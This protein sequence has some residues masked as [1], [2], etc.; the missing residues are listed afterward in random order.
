MSDDEWKE[1]EKLAE[2]QEAI[3]AAIAGI[4]ERLDAGEERRKCLWLLESTT[5]SAENLRKRFPDWE[6]N[7]N[8]IVETLETDASLVFKSAQDL[9][10]VYRCCALI[11]GMLSEAEQDEMPSIMDLFRSIRP[12]IEDLETLDSGDPPRLSVAELAIR[13]YQPELQEAE[14]AAVRERFQQRVDASIHKMFERREAET[15]EY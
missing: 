4:R 11:A 14:R 10:A 5:R 3:L 9:N 7:F 6:Q 8:K 1:R 12:L 2:Q 15:E 13:F